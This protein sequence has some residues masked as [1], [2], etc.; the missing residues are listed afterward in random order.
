MAGAP[1]GSLR[2]MVKPELLPVFLMFFFWGL[3]TGGLWLVRPLFAFETGGTF[4]LVALVSSV[5]AMPRIITGPVTGYLTDRYGRKPFVLI[6]SALHVIAMVGDFY[7]DTYVPFLLLEILGGIG[8]SVW[9]TSA[10][11]L[12]ADSTRIETRGRVV[13]V[14]EMSSRVGLLAGPILAGAIGAVFGLRYIFFFIAGCKVAVIIVTVLWV[15]ETHKRDPDKAHGWQ[16]FHR[17]KI[18]L[19]MFR[20]RAFL[21]LAIGTV[22]ASMVGQGTGAFRTLFPPQTKAVAGLDEAQIGFL[23]AIAVGL[24]IAAALP[25]GYVIDRYGRKM[26][27]L[28]GLLMTALAAYI[29]AVMGSFQLAALAVIIFGLSEAFGT[30]TLQVY[31]MDLA[32]EDKRGA[33]LGVWGLFMNIGQIVGPLVVGILADVYGFAFAFYFVAVLLVI[34]SGIVAIFGRETRHS[35]PTSI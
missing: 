23:L 17:P 5:S 33:F 4:L 26:P 19:L 7:I 11:V 27:L 28:G 1:S 2:Q 8:I 34:G 3:G 14:R 24:S 12:M 13:A 31:A 21:A 32:P 18:D 10:S 22:A 15:K 6:G 25:A 9:M 30:G 35:T 29:M 20:T 16:G